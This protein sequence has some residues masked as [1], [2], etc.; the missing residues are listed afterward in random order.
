MPPTHGS[1]EHQTFLFSPQNEATARPRVRAAACGDGSAGSSWHGKNLRATSPLL[2]K[3][4][5][6]LSQKVCVGAAGTFHI[7][8]DIQ[9][10]PPC[11][12]RR[13]VRSTA[14]F[15][16]F[17]WG[18][19]PPNPLQD[20]CQAPPAAPEGFWWQKLPSPPRRD[21][22]GSPAPSQGTGTQPTSGR[23]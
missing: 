4:N 2:R 8:L 13:D 17:F 9:A 6:D 16:R 11:P 3:T 10:A 15:A 19:Q 20:P 5:P 1:D 23:H 12:P 7:Q 21:N 18:L 22:F 14:R